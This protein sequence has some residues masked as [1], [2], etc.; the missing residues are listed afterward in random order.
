M[1]GGELMEPSDLLS[2]ELEQI[3]IMLDI[4]EVMHDRLQKNLP[5]N[6]HDL[7]K[8]VRF[9]NL[10]VHKVHNKKEEDIIFPLLKK[11]ND[12][13]SSSIIKDIAAENSLGELYLEQI[14]KSIS[15]YENGQIEAV[16]ELKK[17]MKKYLNLEKSHVQKEELFVLP[18]CK[19]EIP[20]SE[21][22]SIL[23]AMSQHDD[24]DFGAGMHEKFH[25][26]FEKVINKM[27]KEYYNQN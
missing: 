1:L 17:N 9:F 4:L 22:S 12:I 16:D 21:Q 19:K 27:K 7:K 2:D 20:Q 24:M 11:Y 13:Q 10:F 8:I 6:I 25:Q 5:I 3:Y 18:L 23:K 26:A 15:N 14:K